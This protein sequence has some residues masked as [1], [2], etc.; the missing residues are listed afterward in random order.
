MWTHRLAAALN[1]FSVENILET[2]R[3]FH[4]PALNLFTNDNARRAAKIF[5][6]IVVFMTLA[7]SVPLALPQTNQTHR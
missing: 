2:W 1:L 4:G 3:A 7:P 6:S 5:D